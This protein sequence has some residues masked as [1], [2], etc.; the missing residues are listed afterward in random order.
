MLSLHARP[1]VG[2]AWLFTHSW[3]WT[4]SY[5][6]VNTWLP[7]TSSSGAAVGVL[8]VEFVGSGSSTPPTPSP[9]L[10]RVAVEKATLLT[11]AALFLGDVRVWLPRVL[12]PR[13]LLLRVL[14]PRVAAL[15]H[16]VA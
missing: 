5:T 14:L 8:H 9:S 7:V 12:L 6:S 15:V 16:L 1:V 4:T 13:V 11:S 2:D 3:L 10:L